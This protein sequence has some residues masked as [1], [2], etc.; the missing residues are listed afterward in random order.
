MARRRRGVPQVIAYWWKSP[1]MARCAASSTSLGGGKF[2]I[3][4][5]RLIPPYWLLTRV[6]SRITDSVKPCTRLEIIGAPWSRRIRRARAG[7]AGK[8]RDEVLRQAAAALDGIHRDALLQP[9]LRAFQPEHAPAVAGLDVAAADIGRDAEVLYLR[10]LLA[11][12]RASPPPAI[13]GTM[14]TSSPCLSAVFAH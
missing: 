1:S 7:S 6:I 4:W 12:G 2:G 10:W 3:P 9:L 14:D 8:S 11:A 13:A 5:A